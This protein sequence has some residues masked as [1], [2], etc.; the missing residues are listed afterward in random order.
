MNIPEWNE[1]IKKLANSVRTDSVIRGSENNRVA[2]IVEPRNTDVLFDLL[3]WTVRLLSPHGWKFI[4]FCGVDNYDAIRT[5][6]DDLQISDIFEIR[7]MAVSN[8]SIWD[9]N[10]R[11]LSKEFWE[12]IP[13][14]HILIYQT[15]SVLLDG[16]LESFLQYDYVGAPFHSKDRFARASTIKYCIL[17]K[18]GIQ[19]KIKYIFNDIFGQNGGLSLRRKS[20]M[21]KCLDADI[22]K[23]AAEDTYFSVRCENLINKP[24]KDI[25]KQFSVET[26]YYDNPKGY[27]KPWLDL[28][29]NMSSIL[30]FIESAAVKRISL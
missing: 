24:H 22:D 19:N 20:A 27:H 21:L 8:L 9:Y 12:S 30:N 10:S 14:E 23:N 3:H 16:D 13:Y 26:I 11:L 29:P 6:A 1:K 18:L 2:I 25:A 15:D 4:V 17:T 7:N 28:S 5:F